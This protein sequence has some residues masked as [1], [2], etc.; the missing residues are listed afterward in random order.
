MQA[1]EPGLLLHLGLN[2][3]DL[4][5]MVVKSSVHFRGAYQEMARAILPAIAPGAV[6]ADLSRLPYRYAQR[7]PARPF[8]PNPK[9]SNA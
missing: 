3:A 7:K 2:P 1:S 9:R 4:P 6:E 8:S 5:I